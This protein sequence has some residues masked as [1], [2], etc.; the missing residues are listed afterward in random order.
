MAFSESLSSTRIPRRF[1]SPTPWCTC[2]ITSRTPSPTRPARVRGRRQLHHRRVEAFELVRQSRKGQVEDADVGGHEHRRT[3]EARVAAERAAGAVLWP[4]E[5][6]RSGNVLGADYQSHD[7]RAGCF[8]FGVRERPVRGS[9]SMTWAKKVG[10]WNFTR[11]VP[12][13]FDAPIKA[14]PR[15]WNAAFGFLPTSRPDVDSGRKHT[16]WEKQKLEKLEKR[17]VLPRRGHGAAEGRR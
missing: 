9:I 1:S 8:H 12:C 14:G 4:V 10:R 2:R 3:L 13:H 7:R 17:R 15:E 5:P 6:A 11:V 16:G